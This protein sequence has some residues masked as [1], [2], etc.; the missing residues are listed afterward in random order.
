MMFPIGTITL[1][2]KLS[3]TSMTKLSNHWLRCLTK[4]ILSEWTEW[5]TST[6]TDNLAKWTDTQHVQVHNMSQ[7][8]WDILDVNLINT[9]LDASQMSNEWPRVKP[10]ELY[11]TDVDFSTIIHWLNKQWPSGYIM[12][13]HDIIAMSYYHYWVVPY[14]CPMIQYLCDITTWYKIL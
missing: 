2:S 12:R 13:M 9:E 14:F 1:G 5:K 4:K 3:T 11:Q 8:C 6:V 7:P 10:G